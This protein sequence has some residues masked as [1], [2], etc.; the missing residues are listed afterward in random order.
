MKKKFLCLFL[1][2]VI[3]PS[4]ITFAAEGTYE[5]TSV[6]DMLE[7]NPSTTDE[8]SSNEEVVNSPD[9]I[10]D[11]DNEDDEAKNK[12]ECL[13]D[14]I[15]ELEDDEEYELTKKYDHS[16]AQVATDMVDVKSFELSIVPTGVTVNATEIEV[17]VFELTNIERAKVGLPSLIWNNDIARAARLHSQDLAANNLVI[18]NLD[19]HTGSDGS[20]VGVRLT[21]EGVTFTGWA[22]NVAPSNSSPVILVEALMNSPAHKDN[23]LHPAMTHLGV[24]FYHN[25][26]NGRF[27]TTQ[28]FVASTTLPINTLPPVIT[29][30]PPG[31]QQPPAGGGQQPPQGGGQQPPGQ[32]QPSRRNGV[33]RDPFRRSRIIRPTRNQAITPQAISQNRNTPSIATIADIPNQSFSISTSDQL[34]ITPSWIASTEISVEGYL[35]DAI[36][37]P[38][39]TANIPSGQY[40]IE[41]SGLPNGIHAPSYVTIVNNG[42]SLEL[43]VTSLILEGTHTINVTILDSNNNEL[44][45]NTFTLDINAP[46]DTYHHPS[47]IQLADNVQILGSQSN[48]LR[49][50]IGDDGYL[51]PFKDVEQDQVMVPLRMVSEAFG[52]MVGWI[53]S[54]RTATVTRDDITASIQADSPLPDGMGR[55]AIVND[56]LFAPINYIAQMLRA[57]IRWADDNSAVYIEG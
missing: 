11:A 5:D 44:A 13:N 6:G 53:E 39:T 15:L 3:V 14:N 30:P 49:L 4:S 1:A 57:R 40:T 8:T 31:E 37:I 16:Y 12:S 2:F 36:N 20:N 23:L 45:V 55:P 7:S 38:V 34:T 48:M 35:T 17:R 28:K 47:T 29:T 21:R 41:V 46:E 56:R 54:T 51:A 27:Y 42:F 26:T 43:M 32:I 25:E 19:F 52:S 24:G 9:W 50:T 18:N 33:R 22:E 10:I